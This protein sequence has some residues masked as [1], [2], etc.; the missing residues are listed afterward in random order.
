MLIGLA[1]SRPVF[2]EL[3]CVQIVRFDFLWARS[4]CLIFVILNRNL[5]CLLHKLLLNLLLPF[6]I[7]LYL[8]V[9]LANL[10]FEDGLG[11]ILRLARYT[12]TI[13]DVDVLRHIVGVSL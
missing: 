4:S 5:T 1:I 12:L 6:Y 9:I 2:R 13:F 11:V 10:L 3:L 8:L 7:L